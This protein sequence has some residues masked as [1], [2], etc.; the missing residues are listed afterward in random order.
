MWALCG[1]VKKEDYKRFWNTSMVFNTL[2]VLGN[3]RFYWEKGV[4]CN[5]REKIT[6]C[7]APFHG[8]FMF[9]LK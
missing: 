7:V 5:T 3:G 4:C 6:L 1:F 8:I 9:L 2:C